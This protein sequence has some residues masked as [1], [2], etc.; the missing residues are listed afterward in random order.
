ML[1]EARNSL[2]I[3]DNMFLHYDRMIISV[4]LRKDVLKYLHT[5]HPVTYAMKDL[6]NPNSRKRHEYTRDTNTTL[7]RNYKTMGKYT[8]RFY[9]KNGP[10]LLAGMCELLL[11]IGRGILIRNS[12]S[13][14]TISCLENMFAR[15]TPSGSTQRCPVEAMLGRKLNGILDNLRPNIQHIITKASYA[16]KHYHDRNKR[17][18][19]LEDSRIER[20]GEIIRKGCFYRYTSE[21]EDNPN[22]ETIITYR[23]VEI[24]TSSPCGQKRPIRHWK[25][26][27][28]LRGVAKKKPYEGSESPMKK[29]TCIRFKEEWLS[30]LVE[31]DLPSST[32][33]QKIQ[34]GDIL[35]Q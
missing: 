6:A 15:I 28:I 26:P 11:K 16:P 31:I 14:D 4:I 2:S 32:Y 9:C 19:Q 27:K 3:E 34:L 13:Q 30:E 17:D 1:Y 5:N 21:C 12:T 25:P 23:E 7:E 22:D 8:H 33:K 18:R 20:N 24:A 10:L 29:K 35:M